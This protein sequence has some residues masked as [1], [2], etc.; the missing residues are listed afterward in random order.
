MKNETRFIA[1]IVLLLLF[2]FSVRL[3]NLVSKLQDG[4]SALLT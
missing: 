3:R 4:G 1:L 2:F